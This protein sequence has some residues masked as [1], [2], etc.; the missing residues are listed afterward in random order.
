[1]ILKKQSNLVVFS[2]LIAAVAFTLLSRPGWL[3][4]Q[5]IHEE[6]VRDCVQ[7]VAAAVNENY[8][9]VKL[10]AEMQADLLDRLEKR[11]FNDVGSLD[12][13][14]ERLTSR[15]VALTQD[16][17][18]VV[19]RRQLEKKNGSDKASEND[20]GKAAADRAARREAVGK[21][22][23]F[24]IQ[25]FEILPGNIAYLNFTSFYRDYEIAEILAAEM[26]MASNADAV[27]L[28]MRFNM[29][30]SAGAISL[31]SSYFFEG[32]TRKLFDVVDRSGN[33][34]TYS[35]DASVK[36]RDGKRPVFVL[37]HPT[38]FSAGEGLAFIMQDQ[39][40]G[41]VI[42][43]TTA[44]AAN[45]GRPYYINEWF[46]VNV[47][48]GQVK[49]ANSGKNWEGTGVTP[50]VDSK[51]KDALPIAHRAAITKLIQLE[52]DGSRKDELQSILNQIKQAPVESDQNAD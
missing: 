36:N 19:S 45:P 31:L 37:V 1:M 40:R 5:E 38:T 11:E 23:N 26:K 48:N 14:A 52:P 8:F 10:A 7:K 35:T 51:G 20:E 9:D 41:I 44:G 12:D 6:T 15:L 22:A 28:D 49:A 29:G 33:V 16:K 42:G 30:G 13:L 21:R 3:I 43:Q 27:I 17:H 25:K 34:K 18:L 50:D 39:K 4:A 24:G 47:P 46:E 32:P 2:V